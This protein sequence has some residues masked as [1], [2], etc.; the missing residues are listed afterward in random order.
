MFLYNYY[1]GIIEQHKNENPRND[2]TDDLFLTL[3][4][5][6]SHLANFPSALR[7]SGPIPR[8]APITNCLLLISNPPVREA[9]QQTQE[10]RQGY[11]EEERMYDEAYK[12]IVLTYILE[13]KMGM[14]DDEYK[15]TV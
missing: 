4:R 8:P 10:Q 5:T 1:L 13:D 11:A 3:P 14:M 12:E 6:D 2:P 9:E 15:G 7:V